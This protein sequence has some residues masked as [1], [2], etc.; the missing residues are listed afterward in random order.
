LV[1]AAVVVLA[2]GA[3]GSGIVKLP[4]A[5]TSAAPTDSIESPPP[6]DN[7]ATPAQGVLAVG[8]TSPVTTIGLDSNGAS[9][10]VSAPGQDWDGLEI[11]VPAGAWPGAT[12]Q[13][14]AEPITRS[15]FGQ[16]VTPISPLY[17]V[18]G[19]EGMAP[20]PVTLK[21]P[22]SIPDGSFAMGFFY[23]ASSGQLEGMPLLA[24]DGT[25]VTI[26]TEHF[27]SFFLSL[28]DGAILPETIDSGFRPG[29]DDWQFPNYGSYVTP[30]GNCAGEVLT[31]AYY[32]IE[33]RL[34]GRG[35]PLH[36]P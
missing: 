26:A 18:S 19:A 23:D 30:L 35:L 8:D 1:L 10:T 36:G 29:V 24:E 15:S 3:L 28:V 31:E 21:I 33:R 11:D 16:L 4:G 5:G 34:K 25:S 22:A 2:A 12:L 7:L 14:T 32:Y 27:S 13:V 20:D 17:T 6:I 9:T